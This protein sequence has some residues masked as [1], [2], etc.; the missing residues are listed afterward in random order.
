MDET[1]VGFLMASRGGM[2]SR[3]GMWL[4]HRIAKVVMGSILVATGIFELSDTPFEHKNG[5]ELRVN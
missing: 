1:W 5:T 3:M 2:K 4:D